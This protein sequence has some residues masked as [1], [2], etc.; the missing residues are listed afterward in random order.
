MLKQ[1]Q[2]FLGFAHFY[3]RFCSIA[4]PL[5]A[6]TKA[7]RTPFALNS[8]AI[9]AFRHFCHQFN[10]APIFL[11][12]DPSKPFVVEVEASNVAVGAI[13]S[14]RD[15][16]LKLHHCSFLSK[17]LN[18]TQ[19]QYG[20][21]DRELLGITGSSAVVT[22]SWSGSQVS[23]LSRKS[24]CRC[25]FLFQSNRRHITSSCLLSGWS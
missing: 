24:W 4:A 17:T 3:Q 18:P 19:Q 25:R 9:K 13:H 23:D 1:L 21:G 8:E 2:Y 5:T 10:F 15:P 16:D 22:R 20:V 7:S 12:P 11:H 6:L 14:Q